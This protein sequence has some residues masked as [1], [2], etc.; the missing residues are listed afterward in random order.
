[1]KCPWL[2]F[3]FSPHKMLLAPAFSCWAFWHCSLQLA[4]PVHP[5]RIQGP[6]TKTICEGT[7]GHTDHSHWHERP[8]QGRT[9]SIRKDYI[10]LFFSLPYCIICIIIM[11]VIGSS[12]FVSWGPY[13]LQ[14]KNGLSA[15]LGN[16]PIYVSGFCLHFICL[17]SFQ[18]IIIKKKS[19]RSNNS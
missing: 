17:F 16:F 5:V 2:C 11:P 13:K 6:V 9:I 8:K 12:Y 1:M 3:S 14:N 15:A 19:R 4:A 10:A 7:N 18:D